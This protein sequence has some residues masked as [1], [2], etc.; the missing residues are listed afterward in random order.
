MNHP[1]PWYLLHM[2]WLTDSEE[3]MKILVTGGAGF[4]GSHCVDRLVLEG[5]EVVIVDNLSTGKRRNLNRAATFYK[6]DI[7]S[8]RLE[9]VFRKERP[10]LLLHLAAQMDVRRSVEDPVFDARVNILGTLNLLQQA[11]KHG[12]RKVIFA[13]SGG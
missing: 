5:H 6:L 12:T 4:I 11:V 7:Q 3:N 1:I 10:S 9:Q 13:S 2:K 8:S